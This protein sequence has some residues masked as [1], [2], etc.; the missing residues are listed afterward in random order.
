MA[1][2]Q[3]RMARVSVGILTCNRREAV[4]RAIRSACEQGT[5]DLEI[6]VVDSASTDGTAEAVRRCFPQVKYIR[7]PR[8]LGCPAGRNY[9]YANCTGDYIV[10]V[11]DDGFLGAGALEGVVRVFESDPTIGIVAMRQVF[12]DDPQAVCASPEGRREVGSF[13]GGVCAFRRA[14]LERIGYYPEDFFLFA[15]EAYLAIRA[16]DAGYRIVYDPGIVMWHPRIG[17]SASK[18]WD[19]YRFRN[20]L[21][22]VTRL[23]PGWLMLK[24]LVLRMGSYLLISLRRGTPHHYLRAV[25]HVLW[26]LPSTLLTRSACGAAAVHRYFALRDTV[27][28]G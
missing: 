11:D 9:I 22:V 2:R 24:Y 6:V 14:M 20:A 27:S 10:N 3:T 21:L 28:K 25:A 7:L 16:M 26:T 15:E 4:L 23:F 17:A 1:G 12:T 18:R 8:N 19:Y 13:W 5:D